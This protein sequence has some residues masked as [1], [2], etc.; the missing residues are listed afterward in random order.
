MDDD[1]DAC[2][3][4]DELNIT[5][6]DQRASPSEKQ[7]MILH[8]NG[9]RPSEYSAGFSNTADMNAFVSDR[10]EEGRAFQ[11]RWGAQ[12]MDG[13]LSCLNRRA[14]APIGVYERRQRRHSIYTLHVGFLARAQ[15]RKL[16]LRAGLD[17]ST[18]LFLTRQIR[19]HLLA[20]GIGA[21]LGLVPPNFFARARLFASLC[22]RVR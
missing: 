4:F 17:L 5:I 18:L 20:L 16:A 22:A 21:S 6:P 2:A 19:S 11:N 10:V 3:L 9:V 15:L 12:P 14:R 8:I 1:F 13:E 7:K